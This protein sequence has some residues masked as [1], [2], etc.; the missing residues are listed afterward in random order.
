ME[1]VS[2]KTANIA[3]VSGMY[4]L[5]AGKDSIVNPVL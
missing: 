4:L 5:M 1:H 2:A 3:L